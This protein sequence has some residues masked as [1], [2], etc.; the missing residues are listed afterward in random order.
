MGARAYLTKPAKVKEFLR[1]I[2]EVL[3][4]PAAAWQ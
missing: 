1:T 2:D 3:S 4:T